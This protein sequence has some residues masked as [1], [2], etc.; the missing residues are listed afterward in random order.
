MRA[1]TSVPHARQTDLD[2]S[3]AARLETEGLIVLEGRAF[4]L[5]PAE[6]DLLDPSHGSERA[7]NISLGPGGVRGAAEGD[8]A[9]DRLH[10]L[11]ARYRGWARDT[12]C[13]LAPRYR[14]WIETGR[15]S[16]R[17]R[18]VAEGAISPRKDDRRLH[19][20]AFASQPTQGRRILRVFVN[21]N[22]SGEPRV[23]R[24]GE[25]FESHAR[26]FAPSAR[27][28]AP[29]EAWLLNAVGVT[30]SR[31]TDYDQLM[32][33]MHDRA[34][35]D[36]AYQAQAPAREVAFEPGAA[37]IVY[38][39]SV[40]HAAIAGRFALEQTFY[41]PLEA[42]A[43]AAA[44]PANVLERVTGRALLPQRRGESRIATPLSVR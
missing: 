1:N 33:Q 35:L 26:R 41:L 37:W 24:V 22:P 21:V 34:K 3:F 7:K 38:T 17:T 30:R 25:D 19:V 9:L 31:R 29:G 8:P 2:D 12:L 16:L 13:D 15:T 10:A 40:V 23:W 6:A 27:A 28:L 44:A 42:M 4:S 18:D 14:P 43:A 20:D 32:L 5:T 36:E 39:D 11:M